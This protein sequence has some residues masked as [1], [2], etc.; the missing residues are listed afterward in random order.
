ML[1]SRL[2]TPPVHGPPPAAIA[3]EGNRSKEDLLKFVA[4]KRTTKPAAAADKA[5]P[6]K[7]AEEEDE[8]EDEGHEEL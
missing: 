4:D 7:E 6:K 3:Y 5:A 8:E 1:A 2:Y